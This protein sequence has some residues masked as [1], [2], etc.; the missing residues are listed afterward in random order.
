VEEFVEELCRFHT[1]TKRV[2]KVDIT[3]RGKVIKAGE[4]IIAATQSRNRN[5]EVWAKG[6]D[7]FDIHRKRMEGKE[8]LGFGWVKHR[9]IAEE[10]AG[11]ELEAVFATIF[12]KLLDLRVA[13]LLEAVKYFPPRKDVGIVELP[14]LF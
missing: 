4:G 14:A 12:K 6:A 13:I 10:L 11:V 8:A 1:A 7:K 5:K 3:L 2:A 9:C